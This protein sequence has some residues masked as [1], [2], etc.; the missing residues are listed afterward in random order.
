MP[1]A[2]RAME[3]MNL[4]SEVYSIGLLS[5]HERYQSQYHQVKQRPVQQCFQ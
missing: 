2:F 3:V 4:Q 5:N 1:V